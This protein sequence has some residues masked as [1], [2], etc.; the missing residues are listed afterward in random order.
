MSLGVNKEVRNPIQFF[1]DMSTEGYIYKAGFDK[2][3]QI[4]RTNDGH[5]AVEETAKLSKLNPIRLFLS[6]ET[7]GAKVT[8]AQNLA[9]MVNK[10]KRNFGLPAWNCNSKVIIANL[11]Y[12]AGRMVPSVSDSESKALI[13]EAFQEAIDALTHQDVDPEAFY[14]SLANKG[15]IFGA[16]GGFN[17]RIHIK[18]AK[19]QFQVSFS[20][21]LGLWGQLLGRGPVVDSAQKIETVSNLVKM[22]AAHKDYIIAKQFDVNGMNSSLHRLGQKITR[23]TTDTDKAKI[24]EKVKE[25]AKILTEYGKIIAENKANTLTRRL[26]RGLCITLPYYIAVGT[27][28]CGALAVNKIGEACF[29]RVV[30]ELGE[31]AAVI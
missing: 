7:P 29:N 31:G 28:N 13:Q 2:K 4:F 24:E 20:E 27:W 22:L 6:R 3:I 23:N 21:K 11:K 26:L 17:E 1:R 18:E 19:G 25:A 8:V 14:K 15:W 10:Y 16:F 5:Y 12:M 30:K 9:E